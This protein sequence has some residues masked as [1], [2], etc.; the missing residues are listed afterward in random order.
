MR[1]NER[2]QV[3]FFFVHEV[4]Q[5]LPRALDDLEMAVRLHLADKVDHLRR[6]DSDLVPL[7][8]K[9]CGAT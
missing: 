2:V 7:E 3:A 4:D 9:L 5:D 6:D 1:L 8:L